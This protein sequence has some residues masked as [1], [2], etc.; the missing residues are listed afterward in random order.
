MPKKVWTPEKDA[1]LLGLF[2]YGLRA[3]DIAEEMGLTVCA[4]ES[5]YTKLKKLQTKEQMK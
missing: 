3:K 1:K 5:R 4:V 2:N